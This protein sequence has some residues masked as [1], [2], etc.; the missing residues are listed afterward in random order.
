MTKKIL[1][2]KFYLA[3][4]G[5]M[6]EAAHLALLENREDEFLVDMHQQLS[7]DAPEST[8][9]MFGDELSDALISF[10]S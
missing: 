5:L 10:L 6:S 8:R 4:I 3:N 2:Q 1:T 9:K 7:K